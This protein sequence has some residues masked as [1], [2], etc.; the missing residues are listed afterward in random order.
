LNKDRWTVVSPY[1]DRALDM[2]EAARDEW[3]AALREQEPGVAADL[4]LLLHE[5]RTVLEEGFLE[6]ISFEP[7]EEMSLVGHLVG[8]YRLIAPIGQG[9]MG[10]VWLGER[11][12][13][14]FEGRAAIKLLNLSLMGAS[15]SRGEE[16]FKREGSLLARLNHPNIARLIDAGVTASGQPYLVLEHVDGRPIDT[17]CDDHALGVDARIRLFLDVLGAVAHAHANLVVHRDV[18]PSNVLV[19]ADGRVKLLD[20]GIAKLLQSDE[21]GV[22]TRDGGGAL[23]PE[24]AAPE[25]VTGREVT[26]ATDVYSLGV[27]LY[28]LLG[29]Q[30]PAGSGC[31]SPADLVKAIVDTDPP[32]LS[33]AVADL[34]P[35][36][37]HRRGLAGVR[38]ETADPGEPDA[39]EWLT[40]NAA[41]RATTPERLR[42]LLR[43]DL[44]TIVSTTLKKSAAERYSSVTALSDDLRRYLAHQPISARP[45]TFAYRMTKFVRRHA[46]AVTATA[47]MV[48]LIACLVTFN[49][50][51]LTAERD[52]AHI[53]AQKSAKVSELLT[54][55]L[56][57]A[58]PFRDRP[59]PTVRDVLDAGAAR[60][61]RELASEPA[62][63]AEMLTAIGRVYQRL[64]LPDKAR[65][66]LEQALATGR[67]V[68]GPEHPR[69]AQT[70]ND[71]GVLKRMNGEAP[72]SVAMLEEALAMRRRLLGA[73]HKDVAVTLSE[74]GRSYGSL[75]DRD[76]AE[77]LAREALAMRRELLGEDHRETATSL[78][79]L[80]LLLWQRADLA[81]AEPLLRQSFE[82]SR[83][84][85][86]AAHPNVG[87]AQAN[88]GLV[89]ADRGQYAA[90]EALF[91]EALAVRSK[92][93]GPKN[94]DLAVT[95]NNLAYPLREQGKFDEAVAAL[96]EA[97]ALTVPFKGD[98]SPPVAHYRANLGRVYLAKGDAVT[99]EPLFR[100]SLAAR[101]HA[102]GDNDWRVGMSRSLLGAALTSLGRHEEAEQELLA[103]RRLLKD[104]PGQ[105]AREARATLTRLRALYDAWGRPDK[106]AEIR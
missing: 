63:L 46:G 64:Q 20:F 2:P 87:T 16:R 54:E 17:Y 55:L 38:D 72:A 66:L 105:Q 82:I 43:G 26:T 29:G 28:L 53:E 98:D 14:R 19:S 35:R 74:L 61:Q 78:G 97:L 103:A 81:G 13:G 104:V 4:D 94:P 15:P 67:S 21:W 52:R 99:A 75:G 58:D 79:D 39:P 30:H 33:D 96:D 11:A 12:D 57:G 36:F 47:G 102:Y 100:R 22:L 51:R 65:P 88:L 7:P 89:I 95:L 73:K 10:S 76:R 62:I 37:A 84:A 101:L 25:Q 18:K 23:T 70:V 50:A 32:R 71:L 83:R 24:F 85:L 41:R 9:G 45:D 44:D 69:V 3:L 34:T 86:G 31:R 77:S 91:R 92:A 49:A 93:L 40:S 48:V 42:R 68:R 59:E 8:A 56:T 106:A 1:L 60:V 27:L 6:D 5:R 80:G 90:A